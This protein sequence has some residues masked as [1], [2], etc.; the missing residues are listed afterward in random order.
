MTKLVM[1]DGNAIMHRAFHA[2]PSHLTTLEGEPINAVY[3]LTSMLF[4]VIE[5]TKPTHLCFAFDRP[6][7]TFRKKILE[8]YQGHR[9]EMDE[10]LAEQFPKA[11]KLIKAFG[12][13]IYEKAGFEADDVIGTISIDSSLRGN[14]TNVLIVTGDKDMLQLVNKNVKLYMP[15]RSLSDASEYGEEK[16]VVKMGVLPKQIVDLKALTG[17]PSD[18]YKGVP[19]IGP[20]TATKLLSEFKTLEKIYKNLKKIPE[21]QKKLLTENKESA[22][23]SQ[24]LARIRTDVEIDFELDKTK[25]ENLYNEKSQKI[26]DEFSFKT[27]KKRAEK[28]SFKIESEKQGK[29]F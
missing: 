16:T 20:K 13:P 26:M 11:Q 27:L 8:S 19:G 23:Q 21:R 15:G 22:F 6:E 14:D 18:N 29:L 10:G 24:D 5:D 1:I 25:L 3:G 28:L 2:V 4:R 7:P 12:I 9:P 17:D